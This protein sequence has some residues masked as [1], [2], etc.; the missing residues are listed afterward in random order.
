MSQLWFRMYAEAVDDEK[1]RLLAFEDRWHFVAIL[2]LKA[3][4]TL[5]SPAPFPERRIALKLGLQ[6]AQLD[7]VKRRLL[8]VQLIGE[9]WQPIAWD[10][11]QFKTD[12]NAAERKQ[13]ERSQ[14]SH[15][16]V[17][18]HRRDSHN[19]VT[20]SEQSRDRTEQ[21]RAD[22]HGVEQSSPPSAQ[23]SESPKRGSKRCPKDFA[24]TQEMRDWAKKE[25]PGVPIDSETAAFR[26]YEFRNAHSDW[27]GTWRNWMRNEQK[28]IKPP[29]NGGSD[30]YAN[31]I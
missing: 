21:S 24:L 4:G 28:K 11:R 2:C 12:H 6:P 8:E 18:T 5:D 20:P 25:T 31:A 10:R 1:L 19:D 23:T 9:D 7:E 14:R 13:K 17:T 29:K 15:K 30:P 22:V 3:L 26:D 16:H 27:L